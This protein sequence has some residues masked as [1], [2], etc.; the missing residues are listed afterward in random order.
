MAVSKVAFDGHTLID[1]TGDTATAADVA[2]GKTFH[3]ANGEQATGINTGGITPTGTINIT[4]NGDTDVTSYATAHVDVP[5]TEASFAYACTLTI[6]LDNYLDVDQ[7]YDLGVRYRGADP[8][9]PSSVVW[10][11]QI[12]HFSGVDNADTHVI[13]LTPYDSEGILK[14]GIYVPV[15]DGGTIS[16][17]TSA[18]GCAPRF[19]AD[20]GE[21]G[22]EN[23]YVTIHANTASFV[24]YVDGV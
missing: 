14:D 11:T 19:V 12:F 7:T 13:Y 8:D 21:T 2:T 6:L 24:V 15:G 9:D 18:I 22:S 1:L 3:L 16:S 4:A 17:V 10:R 5:D 23:V 20:N